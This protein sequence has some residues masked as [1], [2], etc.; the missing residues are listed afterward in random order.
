[1]EKLLSITV[2]IFLLIQNNLGFKLVE[3][4]NG[5]EGDFFEGDIMLV[6][7]LNS[8]GI[9]ARNKW[10][11]DGQGIVRVPYSFQPN[12]YS[13]EFININKI[14]FSRTLSRFVLRW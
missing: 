14:S 7:S 10:L 9:N 1:M 13:K 11:K 4:F 3:N 5:E 12:Q 8:I 2:I 6:N